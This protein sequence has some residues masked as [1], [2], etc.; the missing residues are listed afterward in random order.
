MTL[1]E[2]LQEAYLDWVNNFLTDEKFAEHYG[3]THEEALAVIRLGH[4]IHERMVQ[5]HKGVKQ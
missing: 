3:L 5:F 4:N 1:K 2:T